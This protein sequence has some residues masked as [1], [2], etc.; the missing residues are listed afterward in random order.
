MDKQTTTTV[1]TTKQNPQKKKKG[2]RKNNRK[3]TKVV[4]QSGAVTEPKNFNAVLNSNETLQRVRKVRPVVMSGLSCYAI[5]LVCPELPVRER[6]IPDIFAGRSAI[7]MNRRVVQITTV[8]SPTNASDNGR[9]CIC[10]QPKLGGS[11]NPSQYQTALVK[12]SCLWDNNVVWSDPINWVTTGS[13]RKDLRVDVNFDDLCAPGDEDQLFDGD[14]SGMVIALPFGN[15]PTRD[16]TNVD[17]PWMDLGITY[18]AGVFTMPAGVYDIHAAAIGT[19]LGPFSAVAGTGVT[20]T[21]LDRS[22][23][24]TS[25]TQCTYSITATAPNGGTISLT[26]G[27]AATLTS[28][29]IRFTLVKSFTPVNNQRVTSIRAVAASMLVKNVFSPAYAGG[30]CCAARLPAG[31][32]ENQVASSN[33]E[34]QVQFHEVM[35]TVPGAY[36]GHHNDGAYIWW[37]PQDTDDRV[38]HRPSIH[39]ATNLPVLAACG[40]FTNANGSS[41]NVNCL[42]AILTYVFE[43]TTNDRLIPTEKAPIAPVE[44]AEAARLL[45]DFPPAM[46]NGEHAE[47][48]KQWFI[49]AG[50]KM[51]MF[52]DR[53]FSTVGQWFGS[54]VRPTAQA[55]APAAP[56]ISDIAKIAYVARPH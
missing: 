25:S 15:N 18:S 8:T 24:G 47:R 51:K 26:L 35:A 27:A 31:G 32:F 5:Q 13:D 6:R 3:V 55:L 44:L 42:E 54:L 39:Q 9:W 46:A 56:A 48:I 22:S 52:F 49:N 4:T 43:Y 28:S 38:F 20:L 50:N 7:Y 37:Y 12:P 30:I 40:Q 17:H 53:T 16:T 19:T 45:Q 33:A 29:D 14:P 1:T 34:K 2:A 41:N 11:A 23:T 21:A 36:Q 10:F